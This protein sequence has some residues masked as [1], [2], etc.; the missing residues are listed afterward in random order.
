MIGIDISLKY[1]FSEKDT[2][3]ANTCEK[4][5][6]IISYQ[7]NANQNEVP[8]HTHQHGWNQTDKNNWVRRR[9]RN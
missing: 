4:M 9:W 3:M 6:N 1:L 8:L 5:L 7:G 2:Q